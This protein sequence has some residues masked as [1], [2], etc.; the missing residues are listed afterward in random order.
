MGRVS[1]EIPARLSALKQVEAAIAQAAQDTGFD[2][3]TTYACQ[4]AVCEAC[5][6]IITHGYERQEEGTISIILNPKP[7]ELAIELRDRAQPFN[8]AEP[9]TAPPNKEGDPPVG[10][11][12]LVI[13]HR[14]MDEIRYQRQGDENT[15]LLRKLGPK[16]TA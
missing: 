3:R 12:G 1:L 2:E 7:G 4:L 5:E 9:A 14:V 11:L 6:N 15:L 13:L 16:T 10:G 8:P